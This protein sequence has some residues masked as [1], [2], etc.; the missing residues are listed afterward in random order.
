MD[1]G[2]RT[3]GSGVPEIGLRLR[4]K[5]ET[6]ECTMLPKWAGDQC[7]SSSIPVAKVGG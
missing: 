4:V 2:L 6:W 1:L 3:Q 7:S 5:I